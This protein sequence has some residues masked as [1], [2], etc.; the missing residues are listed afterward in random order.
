MRP[1]LEDG[2]FDIVSERVVEAGPYV[3][4]D[5]IVEA[6]ETGGH[7]ELAVEVLVRSVSF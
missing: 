3:E 7:D 6:Q 1:H 2:F 5:G 4:V